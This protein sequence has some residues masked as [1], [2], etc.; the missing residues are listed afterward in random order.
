MCVVSMISDHYFDKWSPRQSGTVTT[1]PDLPTQK[2]IDEFRE[3]LRK[4]REYDKANNQPDCEL[5]S[6]KDRLLKLAEELGIKI[7]F[8]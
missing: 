2:E 4:A 5:Q 8:L 7:D 6:K 1:F 3:L